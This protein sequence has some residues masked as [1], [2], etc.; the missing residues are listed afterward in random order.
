MYINYGTFQQLLLIS[1]VAESTTNLEHIK[2][3]NTSSL[4]P[5]QNHLPHVM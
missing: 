2:N 3:E 4:P 1:Y 5:L